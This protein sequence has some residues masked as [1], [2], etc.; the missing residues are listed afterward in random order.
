MS[1]EGGARDG[2]VDGS[3]VGI[4]VVTL[5]GS[6]GLRQ[7]IR[8]LG[9]LGALLALVLALPAQAVPLPA[10]V[11]LVPSAAETTPSS[12]SGDSID[13]PAIWV[14]TADPGRSLV[15][16]NNQIGRASC[17]ERV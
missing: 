9:V 14:N 11:V 5:T 13:D 3:A 10:D 8:T 4:A 1:K 17:R 16:G 15:V 2:T 7:K 12:W 6:A